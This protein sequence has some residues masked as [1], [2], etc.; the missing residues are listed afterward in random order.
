LRL[1]LRRGRE[2]SGTAQ[3]S[4]LRGGKIAG[5]VVRW[6]SQ[7]RISVHAVYGLQ[8][9]TVLH[10]NPVRCYGG[11]FKFVRHRR[12]R[13]GHLHIKVSDFGGVAGTGPVVHVG[14]LFP[15]A[16]DPLPRRF[17]VKFILGNGGRHEAVMLRCL[18]GS[19]PNVRN[20]TYFA[21]DASGAP[22]TIQALLRRSARATAKPRP[23]CSIAGTGPL[24]KE[25]ALWC[26]RR[27]CVGGP[28]ESG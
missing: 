19:T 3:T 13:H 1:S 10:D 2:V 12:P 27:C 24:A 16:T 6:T 17:V 25:K 11:A 5:I 26:M 15:T 20:R 18:G 8:R 4:G 23:G 22:L 21:T 14:G 7:G 9:G 28:N